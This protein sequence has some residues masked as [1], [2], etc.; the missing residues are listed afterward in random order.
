MMIQEKKRQDLAFLKSKLDLGGNWKI[1]AAQFHFIAC[2]VQ[3]NHKVTDDE[4]GVFF[5]RLLECFND[6]L[7]GQGLSI[8]A[9]IKAMFQE[10]NFDFI[11]KFP[12]CS[13]DFGPEKF[14]DEKEALWNVDNVVDLDSIKENS[15]NDENYSYFIFIDCDKGNFLVSNGEFFTKDV[16]STVVCCVKTALLEFKKPEERASC[17]TRISEIIH[18]TL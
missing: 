1:I 2:S 6:S 14:S 10:T 5:W 7:K 17:L 18:A 12:D 9:D 15:L 8:K 4:L 11:L 13:F 3:S 16:L